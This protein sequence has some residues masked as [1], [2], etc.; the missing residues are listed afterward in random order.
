MISA[1]YGVAAW[2]SPTWRDSAV[3]W[4]DE[5]LAAAGLERTGEVKQARLRP[6]AT[7]LRAPTADGPVWL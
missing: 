5:Q 1:P 7:V 3:S 6:W 2:S 4:L